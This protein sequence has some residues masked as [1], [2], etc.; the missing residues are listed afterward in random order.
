M[1]TC[2]IG[3]IYSNVSFSVF[4]RLFM[5]PYS[6]VRLFWTNWIFALGKSF[7]GKYNSIRW[8]HHLLPILLFRIQKTSN[9]SHSR[10]LLDISKILHV[11]SFSLSDISSF[12]PMLSQWIWRLF[13]DVDIISE[14]WVD[15]LFSGR[16]FHRKRNNP[17]IKQVS[18]V[19]DIIDLGYYKHFESR[20]SLPHSETT[21]LHLTKNIINSWSHSRITIDLNRL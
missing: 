10:L 4:W 15:D 9:S 8:L 17:Y 16:R 20:S 21:I 5:F 6:V 11:Y 7:A 1:F 3:R 13:L 12:V 2:P 14:I 19:V 18:R